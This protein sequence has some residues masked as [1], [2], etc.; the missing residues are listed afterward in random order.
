MKVSGWH[1]FH[2]HLDVLAFPRYIIHAASGLRC[3]AILRCS[4]SGS[5]QNAGKTDISSW[6]VAFAS[7][8]PQPDYLPANGWP[9][10]HVSQVGFCK[11]KGNDFSRFRWCKTY[12]HATARPV[13]VTFAI[14][15]ETVRVRKMLFP[16]PFSYI[17]KRSKINVH[18]RHKPNPNTRGNY[19]VHTSEAACLSRIFR[20]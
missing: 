1:L 17:R 5:H 14:H 20:S 4:E 16:F 18:F 15:P 12:G 2:V 11:T 6:N 9:N 8:G 19:H 3:P 10:G 7:G 13:P